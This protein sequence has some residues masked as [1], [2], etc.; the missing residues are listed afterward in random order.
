MTTLTPEQKM[1]ATLQGEV[2][3]LKAGVSALLATMQPAQRPAFSKAL[4]E[5]GEHTKANQLPTPVP[6]QLIHAFDEQLA[7]MR[8]VAS[9]N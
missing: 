7:S 1:I 6:D 5:L 8:T 3:A 4:E 2:L 9:P